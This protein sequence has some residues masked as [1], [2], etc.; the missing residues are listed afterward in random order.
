MNFDKLKNV[1]YNE[2]MKNHT[3]FRI[4]GTADVFVSPSSPAELAEV[5]SLCKSGGCPYLVMGNGSN[6]L[7][8]DKGIRGV[9]I[10]IGNEMSDCIINGETVYA[11]AGILLSALSA[12][13]IEHSLS[14]FERLSGIPGSLGGGIFMNAGAYGSELCDVIKSVEYLDTNGEIK[15]APV[16]ELEMGYRTSIF[17]KNGGIILSAIMQFK[18][19]NADDIR[20]EIS[21]YRKKRSDK[22]PVDMPSAGSAFKR[23]DGYFAGKLIEDAGLTGCSV[24]GA[25]VSLKH[26]GFI[27]NTGDATAQDV[28]D[29]IDRIR[30]TVR[31]KFGVELEPEIRLIGE[32]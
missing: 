19:G 22:Q 30:D 31:E 8:S 26:A 27:V 24:G 25:Q 7:V 20:R 6:M 21:E 15:T 3:T 9:V 32:R 13:L 12:R 23:P 29:L 2:P 16:S 11:Q 28:L 1:K 17:Q 10:R 18:K 4:G 14:G 5:V